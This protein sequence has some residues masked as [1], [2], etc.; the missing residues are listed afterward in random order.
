MVNLLRRLGYPDRYPALRNWQSLVK[1][2]IRTILIFVTLIA[3]CL[4]FLVHQYRRSTQPDLIVSC[5][6][7]YTNYKFPHINCISVHDRPWGRPR[8]VVLHRVTS[9][10]N[11]L[12]NRYPKWLDADYKNLPLRIRGVEIFAENDVLVYYAEND[13]D[14]KLA[15]INLFELPLD[16]PSWPKPDKL[17]NLVTGTDVESSW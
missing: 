7:K 4:P 8:I 2:G 13:D 1:F 5:T 17:W 10:L 12:E 9:E 3:C 6:A 15:R 11:S 14:P 16:E